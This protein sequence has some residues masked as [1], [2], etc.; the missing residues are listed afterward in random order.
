[1]LLGGPRSGTV[2]GKIGL[3][4][5][6]IAV[7][8]VPDVLGA[9]ATAVPYGSGL[10][11]RSLSCNVKNVSAQLDKVMTPLVSVAPLSGAGART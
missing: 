11:F 6:M 3:F 7:G 10:L 8:V 9:A 4:A 5:A 1:M 2:V